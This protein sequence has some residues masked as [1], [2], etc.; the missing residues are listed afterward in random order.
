M[1]KAVIAG[2]DEAGRGALA[3]PVV[4]A[5][6]V[7]EIECVPPGIVIKDSKQM[8]PEQREVAFAFIASRCPYGIGSVD[9]GG[10]DERGI[11]GATEKAMH[12]AL[13]ELQKLVRPTYL[14]IDGR[15]KFW[16]D[17][18][19]S[20]VIRGDA[21]ESCIAAASILAKVTRDRVMGKLDSEFPEYGFARHKGYGTQI[22]RNAIQKCGESS[23]H[24]RSFLS[25]VGTVT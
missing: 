7:F 23:L 8:T 13:Q 5:A 10:V 9:A 25:R 15:D 12:I 4:A 17:L 24:R 22:H 18:P 19:H 1:P 2:L 11:L 3:G 21:T 20:S 16:F 14:L 6:C